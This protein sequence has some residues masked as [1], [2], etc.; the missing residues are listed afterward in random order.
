MRNIFNALIGVGAAFALGACAATATGTSKSALITTT[1]SPQLSQPA[2]AGTALV[3]IRY[4]AVVE[5]A[6]QSTY[7]SNYLRTPIGGT[8]RAENQ[9]S[10][11]QA[12]ADGAILK[13]NYFALSLYK[14]LVKRLP[15]HSVLLSP[16][17][18]T[19]ADDSTLTSEPIT[20][21]ESIPSVLTVDFA[22]Y[23]FPDPVKMMSG[24]PLTF[25]DLIT[26][27][28][29]IHSDHRADAPTRGVLLSSQPLLHH[30]SGNAASAISSSLNSLQQGQFDT[31][32]SE[33]HFVSFISQDNI[34]ATSTKGLHSQSEQS[35]TRIYPLEKVLLDRDALNALATDSSGAVDPLEDVFSSPLADKVVD[36]LNTVDMT[37]ATMMERAVSIAQFD[38]ALAALTLT[39]LEDEDFQARM[40]YTERLLQAEQRY[41]SVQSLR[42]FDGIHNG[43][44]GAQVRDM[45]GEEYTILEERRKLARQQNIATGLAV[46]GAVAAGV[47]ISQTGRDGNVN[48]GEAILTSTIANAA[49]FAANQAFRLNRQSAAIGANYLT[50]IVPALEEQVSVQVN[51]IDSNETITAIRFEDLR[52]KLQELYSENQRA[53]E[54][55]GSNCSYTH[56]DGVSDGV[57][58]G[59]CAGGKASG[60][61]VGILT[62]DD[63]TSVEY[64][65][66]AE[67]G[68]PNGAGYLIRHGPDS[69][70]SLE[71]SFA[72]GKAN[73]TILVSQAGQEARLRTYADGADIGPA[74]G[75]AVQATPFIET[76]TASEENA[77]SIPT[78]SLLKQTARAKRG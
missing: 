1:P 75:D 51:L 35:S 33:L 32:S 6:A 44:M 37:K 15:E 68:Q 66:T 26:P 16:H 41:L 58:L 2:P 78:A 24:A 14:E 61:G 21:A 53:V 74:K 40:R 8:A 62:Y 55:I 64:Y 46:L 60:A 65:G 17:S 76:G 38:P 9:I 63:G 13:S 4:P 3:V 5:T 25:G 45:L 23:S 69:I 31:A 57:W 27:L 39:G 54:A 47:A 11:A 20:Q 43:E 10:D 73:G 48:I 52:E 70:V 71:G 18:V 50:S 12:I 42:I 49:V 7:H 22:A 72:N 77:S 29:T 56:S 28:V 67:D 19:L 59:E 36:L 30:A 34:G